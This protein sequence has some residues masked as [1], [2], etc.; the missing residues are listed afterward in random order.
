MAQHARSSGGVGRLTRR[1][2]LGLVAGVGVAGLVAACG[3]N[4]TTTAST[5][6]PLAT[7]PQAPAAKQT[8]VGTATPASSPAASPAASPSPAAQAVPGR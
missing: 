5:Q 4:Q 1:S 8:V 3:G 6:V 7:T 2:V